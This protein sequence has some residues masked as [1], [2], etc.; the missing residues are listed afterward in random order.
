MYGSLAA[1]RTYWDDRGNSAPTDATDALATAALVRA[2][3]YV[4]YR[5]VANLSPGY[6][7]TLDIVE[8]ATYEAALLELGTVGFFSKTYTPSQQKVLTGAGTIRWTVVGDSS[9]TYSASPVSTI[10]EAMFEPYIIDRDKPGFY[11]EAVGL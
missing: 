1:F 2:S 3:D 11:I 9:K 5:Y 7:D 4:K 10:I 8:L 6:D